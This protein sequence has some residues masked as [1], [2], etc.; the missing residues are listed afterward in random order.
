ML[1]EETL[2]GKQN[3]FLVLKAVSVSFLKNSNSL[4]SYERPFT[5]PYFTEKDLKPETGFTA[6]CCLLVLN[7]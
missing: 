3:H 1:N 6:L 2:T 4:L 7:T 5:L